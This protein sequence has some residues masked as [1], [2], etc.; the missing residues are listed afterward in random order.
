MQS[1]LTNSNISDEDVR[2]LEAHGTKMT[3]GDLIEMTSL[4]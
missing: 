2:F 1:T 4:I 3:L